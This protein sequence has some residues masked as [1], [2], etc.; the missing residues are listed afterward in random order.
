MTA[1][2]PRRR[3]LRTR[4]LYYIVL[5]RVLCDMVHRQ[6]R[7]CRRFGNMNFSKL[8]TAEIFKITLTLTIDFSVPRAHNVAFLVSCHSISHALRLFLSTFFNP[9]VPLWY[10]GGQTDWSVP[11]DFRNHKSGRRGQGR[12]GK[13]QVGPGGCPPRPSLPNQQMTSSLHPGK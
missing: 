8:V 12:W 13:G 9:R 4:V 6:T 2:T 3:I 1:P 5:H 7:R 10:F 11:P